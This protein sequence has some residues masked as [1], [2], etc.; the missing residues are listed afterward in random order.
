MHEITIDCIFI[1]AEASAHENAAQV[2][3]TSPHDLAHP[4]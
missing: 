3:A 1:I 2:E 4:R